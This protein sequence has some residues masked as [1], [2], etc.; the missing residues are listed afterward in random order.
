MSRDDS[1]AASGERPAPGEG[2]IQIGDGPWMRVTDV[3][4]SFG[5]ILDIGAEGPP[6]GRFRLTDALRK[7]H[8]GA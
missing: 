1:E 8:R 3:K 7:L 2:M 4:V 6:I 5:D